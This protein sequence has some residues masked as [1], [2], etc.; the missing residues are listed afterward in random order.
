MHSKSDRPP[1][2][3]AC[4]TVDKPIQNKSDS[5]GESARGDGNPLS[6]Y[7]LC[8]NGSFFGSSHF[9][10][11]SCRHFVDSLT[12]HPFRWP[13]RFIW[14]SASLFSAPFSETPEQR[15]PEHE[16][17]PAV[18]M[19][20]QPRAGV[21]KPTDP[22]GVHNSS[23]L[24]VPARPDE[25]S[26]PPWGSEDGQCASSR[27]SRQS[28]VRSSNCGASPTKAL[29]QALTPS[30]MPSGDSARCSLSALSIPSKENICPS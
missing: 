6:R 5:H 26:F 27:S 10:L 7:N 20:L 30:R 9:C 17:D 12:G 4:Q 23:S 14:L 28:M 19:D 29:T 25:I 13:V 16:L 2:Q 18:R 3:V 8:K 22:D 11:S 24:C 15:A 1:F 21:V